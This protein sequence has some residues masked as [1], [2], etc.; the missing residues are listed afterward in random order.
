MASITS[1]RE[2]AT[3]IDEE[4]LVLEAI[5]SPKFKR[6]FRNMSDDAY[7]LY[8]TT[9][10]INSQELAT[11]YNMILLKKYGMSIVELLRNLVLG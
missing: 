6:I 2:S 7:A 3:K 1:K 11:N 5:L 8:R 9:G 10:F 4:K